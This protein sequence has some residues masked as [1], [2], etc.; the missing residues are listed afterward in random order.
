MN[1][2]PLLLLVGAAVLFAIMAYHVWNAF[3]GSRSIPTFL[4]GRISRE[5]DPGGFWLNVACGGLLIA[6]SLSVIAWSGTQE[7]WRRVGSS[8]EPKQTTT[9]D[10]RSSNQ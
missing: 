9:P 8:Y 1:Y 6:F 3:F 5:S 4:G 7:L 2:P 10:N